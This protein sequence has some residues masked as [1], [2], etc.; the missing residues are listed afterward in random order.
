MASSIRR[1]AMAAAVFTGLLCGPSVVAQS[2][3]LW[4]DGLN[5]LKN[6]GTSIET[7]SAVKREGSASIR[8]KTAWPTVINL[9]E[10]AVSD[11]EAATLVY[12]ADLRSEGLAGNAYLEMW[13]HFPGG[14]QYFS[15]GLESTITGDSDW[16]RSE[17]RFI[18]QAGQKPSK[19]TL[20]LVI[21]GQGS[22]WVDNVRFDREPLP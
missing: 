13:C 10:I 15:R 17:T 4:H 2:R 11:I 22:V 6:L 12:R 1:S 19:V 20:N 3:E 5:N 8:E 18:L 7:D 21:Q 14:G 9:A 16:K